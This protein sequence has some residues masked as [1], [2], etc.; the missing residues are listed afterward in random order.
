[1]LSPNLAIAHVA[2][3]Q[4]QK[5]V[6]INDAIDAL[7]RAMTDVLEIDF[8]AGTVTL[9]A[10]QFRRNVAFRPSSSLSGSPVL[11]VP[12]L[13]RSFVVANTD[14]VVAI[15]VMRGSTSIPV[16]PLAAFA[17]YAD[18][19]ANGLHATGGSGSGAGAAAFT[20]LADVPSSYTGEAGRAVVVNGSGDGLAFAD[21]DGLGAL[22][23][24]SFFSGATGSFG[25]AS[26]TAYATKGLFFAP[27]RDLRIDAVMAMIDAAAVSQN[28]Y[29]QIAEVS[30]AT[31]SGQIIDVLATSASV[32]T[33]STDMRCYRFPFI[34]PV[35]LVAG[36]TYLI[37]TTLESG[38]GTTANRI[39]TT[40]SGASTCWWIEAPG[41]TFD[42]A[43]Q[44]ASIGLASGQT[45]AALGTGFYGLFLEGYV[46]DYLP[47]HEV[48]QYIAGK[49]GGGAT[50][51][52]HV[53]TRAARLDVSGGPSRAVA[54]IAPDAAAT[55]DL[56]KN[57]AGIGVFTFATD[58]TTATFT[59][60]STVDFAAG[61]VLSI[62][63]PS[64]QDALLEDVAITL[65]LGFL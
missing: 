10:D 4:N 27:S 8:S 63:A 60:T 44:Y 34:A 38:T 48:A 53:L 21:L 56:H 52:R 6:T 61:D 35:T 24:R 22:S 9:T 5:E 39:M 15:T 62:T 30:N 17:F 50:I 12:A 49:P 46:L 20:D 40:A 3:A 57:G 45:P 65:V 64:P 14:A 26:T 36:R 19:T 23:G 13:K 32:P 16:P 33:T 54:G 1:M 51:L 37:S 29:A 47:S 2:A 31:V 55:F 58:A 59:V 11:A 7:D 28:H 43:A 25:S 41:L 18:G 42:G